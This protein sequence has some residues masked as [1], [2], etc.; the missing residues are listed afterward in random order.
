MVEPGER[1][2]PAFAMKMVLFRASRSGSPALRT[3]WVEGESVSQGPREAALQSL[4]PHL[5]S[6]HDTLLLV[7]SCVPPGEGWRAGV[8]IRS[9]AHRDGLLG[10]QS[11]KQRPP[12]HCWGVTVQPSGLVIA[13]VC[14]SLS[15]HTSQVVC[16]GN[17][18]CSPPLPSLPAYARGRGEGPGSQEPH[19]DAVRNIGFNELQN[20]AAAADMYGWCPHPPPTP[21]HTHPCP[22]ALPPSAP[23]HLLQT[24][25]S[26]FSGKHPSDFQ[27][28]S[29][30]HQ[31]CQQTLRPTFSTQAPQVARLAGCSLHPHFPAPRGAPRTQSSR[32]GPRRGC[33]CVRQGPCPDGCARPVCARR[34]RGVVRVRGGVPH[35]ADVALRGLD[36]RGA[37][38]VGA[39]CAGP[40]PRQP[41]GLP[42]RQGQGGRRAEGLGAGAPG[43]PP[44]SLATP[45]PIPSDSTG[46]PERSS[47]RAGR[48]H[49]PGQQLLY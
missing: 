5:C 43:W 42:Q 25:G 13:H 38:A 30:P 40:D 32:L 37:G 18:G 23:A 45:L 6:P 2:V 26:A 14:G 31:G 7:G 44:Y 24:L 1:K 10:A 28:C 29:W 49:R 27:T 46:E 22:P 39:E 9:E 3:S 35:R 19:A 17:G 4:W 33:M 20:E 16:G 48:A 41:A 12:P 15:A 47:G 21:P 11:L 8:S 34:G 36:G